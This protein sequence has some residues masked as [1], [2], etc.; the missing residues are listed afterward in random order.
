MQVGYIHTQSATNIRTDS[1]SLSNHR[2]SL[3]TPYQ[4]CVN[5]FQ[6]LEQR[7]QSKAVRIL[8]A[9]NAIL[10]AVSRIYFVVITTALL[11]G[12]HVLSAFVQRHCCR[13]YLTHT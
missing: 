8:G 1:E 7:F 13:I 10:A 3:V 12:S 5:Y 6:Y 2:T 9:A 4:F 11:A